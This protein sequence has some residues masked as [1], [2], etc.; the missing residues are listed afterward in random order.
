MR[1]T[2]T[3]TFSDLTA[4]MQPAAGGKGGTLARLFRAGYPVPDGFVVL[5]AAFAGDELTSSAWTGVQAQLTRMRTENGRTTFAVRSSA[6]SEDSAEA[7]FAGEFETVLDRVGRVA[8]ARA[9]DLDEDGD[10]DIAVAAFGWLRRGGVYLLYN[11]RRPDGRLEFRTEKISHRPGAVSVLPVEDNFSNNAARKEEH[12]SILFHQPN[13]EFFFE[14]FLFRG[15]SLVLVL[16]LDS[17]PHELL[18]V[19]NA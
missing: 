11:E 5:P 1:P 16:V 6:L 3:P 19:N 15:F 8:D 7:S 10:L 17:I 13:L 9:V 4:E 18:V 12:L 14:V 2:T